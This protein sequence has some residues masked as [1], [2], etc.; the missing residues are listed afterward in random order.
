MYSIESLT[1]IRLLFNIKRYHI[2]ITKKVGDLNWLFMDNMYTIK[3]LSITHKTIIL[4][5]PI[6][7]N[8]LLNEGLMRNTRLQYS[9]LFSVMKI[10]L[11]R[12]GK[13]FSF[14]VE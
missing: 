11:M 5:K 7:L 1:H 9:N 4:S 12:N 13:K 2:S 10:H 3:I 8:K 6:Y 14:H